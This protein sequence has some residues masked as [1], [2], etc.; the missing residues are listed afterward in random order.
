M[1][2][3]S[4]YDPDDNVTVTTDALTKSTSFDYSDPDSNGVTNLEKITGSGGATTTF[5][6]GD[7]F[8]PYSPKTKKDSSNNDTTYTFAAPGNLMGAAD[9][10]TGGTG[11]SSSVTRNTDGSIATAKDANDHT[12]SYTYTSG[13]LTKLVITPPSG[14]VLGTTTINYDNLARVASVVDGKGQ[15]RNLTYDPID[16][17]KTEQ[18]GTP[19][20]SHTY[21]ANGNT[22]QISD[23]TG[24]TVFAYDELNRGLTKAP[25]SRP[26]I[27]TYD[28]VG[29]LKTLD[30]AG[31]R[32]SYRYDAANRVDQLTEPGNKITGFGYDNADRR[33]SIDL[34]NGVDITL[35]YDDDGR[36]TKVQAVKTSTTIVD[37]KYCYA[38]VAI[39]DTSACS[40]I[41]NNTT[42]TR[43]KLTDS[44]LG[45][46]TNYACDTM[47]RLKEAK[48][49]VGGT[50]DFQYVYDKVGNRTK[51]TIN[52]ATPTFYGY[53]T[54]NELCWSKTTAT[55]PGS[56]CTTPSGATTYN[57][58]ANGNMTSST[59]GFSATYNSFDQATSI[60]GAGRSTL[61]P[62]TY[63]GVTQ[64]ERRRAGPTDFTDSALGLQVAAPNGGG[65]GTFYTRDPS[66][67]L[68]SQRTPSG[69]HYYILD[70]LGS[71]VAL[72]DSTGAVVGR[73]SY[74][75]YGKPTFTGS[76]TSSF[77]YASGY[78]DAATKLVK[79][80]ARYYDP[81]LGRWT[82][83]DPV[84][85]NLANPKTLNRYAYVGC[86]PIN[87]TDPSGL[88]IL[89]CSTS[90]ALSILAG[91]LVAA[92]AAVGTWIIAG[93]TTVPFA[94]G[95]AIIGT[96]IVGGQSC[97]LA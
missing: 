9:T 46:T 30:D 44:R 84:A 53:G 42:D 4:E 29:N 45:Q 93:V 85:G 80:G 61:S 65:A 67:N 28:G 38:K 36:Q 7:T 97:L 63:G 47:S 54:A 11:A 34:P 41:Q 32:V 35:G 77:Q 27:Y 14:S 52:A 64:T 90:S 86:D 66:G 72:T 26:T 56:A 20:V 69:T 58:D 73:Y 8:N 92:G 37:L 76:V 94:A 1:A 31:G 18:V 78:Y 6:Y 88:S 19:Q 43:Y 62:M 15:T 2:H 74:E 50:D 33:I 59:A 5:G 89:G 60:T 21:D 68:I 16:R 91:I 51:Q 79:F 3:D 25:P 13:L 83:Q 39:T 81:A 96:A 17:T 82:Q 75:P 12:T 48:T 70:V 87:G 10:T 40:P 23:P 57:H 71:V 24:A 22:T 55:D 49:T 95:A